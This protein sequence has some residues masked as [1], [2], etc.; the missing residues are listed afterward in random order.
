MQQ[1]RMGGGFSGE[2][3]DL[4]SDL[5]TLQPGQICINLCILATFSVA[6]IARIPE[7]DTTYSRL[8]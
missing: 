3:E 8:V 1:G 2:E 5:A 6:A 4:R 7:A